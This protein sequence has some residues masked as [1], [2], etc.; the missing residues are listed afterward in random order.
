MRPTCSAGVGAP[1][2]SRLAS[3]AELAAAAL[4]AAEA[5][6]EPPSQGVGDPRGRVT[7]KRLLGSSQ[8]E[9][10]AAVHCIWHTRRLCNGVAGQGVGL[11]LGLAFLTSWAKLHIA[12]LC[13]LLSSSWKIFVVL[14]VSVSGLESTKQ[15]LASHWLQQHQACPPSPGPPRRRHRQTWARLPPQRR[16]RSCSPNRCLD[17]VKGSAGS[18][19]TENHAVRFRSKK[20]FQSLV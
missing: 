11:G 16:A 2:G 13:P 18:S 20:G 4:V 19:R 1:S 5:P 3:T 17:G 9:H 14:L 6:L 12:S 7:H 8:D 15:A 10:P